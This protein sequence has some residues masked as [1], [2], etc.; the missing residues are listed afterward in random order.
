MALPLDK[1]I[2][3]ENDIITYEYFGELSGVVAC[4][5]SS[6]PEEIV[7]KIAA[8]KPLTA[9]FRDSSFATSTEKVNLYEHFRTVSPETKIRVL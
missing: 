6:V 2:V 1:P 8:M 4:F 3:I 5:N 7:M 9:L